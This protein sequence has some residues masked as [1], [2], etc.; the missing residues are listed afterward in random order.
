VEIG[1]ELK[2]PYPSKL[3]KNHELNPKTKD[4]LEFINSEINQAYLLLLSH[5]DIDPV[6]IELMK[7]SA[8][9][10]IQRRYQAKEPW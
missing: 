2:Q 9:A 5:S 1:T 3:S 8:L 4:Q 6:V 7:L 10:E